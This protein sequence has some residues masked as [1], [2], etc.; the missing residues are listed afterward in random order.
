MPPELRDAFWRAAHDLPI[1]IQSD[2]ADE[3]AGQLKFGKVEKPEGLLR[4]LANAARAGTLALD[5]ARRLRADRAGE[6]HVAENRSKKI[7]CDAE[8]CAKGSRF[9]SEETRKR[10][11]GGEAS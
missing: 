8:A 3:L 6:S 5:F 11:A 2:I 10:I 4:A 7:Q 9:F 1:E